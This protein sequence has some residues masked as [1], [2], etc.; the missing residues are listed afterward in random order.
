MLLVGGT[1]EAAP[2]YDPNR[3]EAGQCREFH[4]L[5]AAVTMTMPAV[6]CWMDTAKPALRCV[7]PVCSRPWDI[8]EKNVT[9]LNAN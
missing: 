9:R 8:G 4:A 6:G 3:S 1:L 7:W 2:I 5:L